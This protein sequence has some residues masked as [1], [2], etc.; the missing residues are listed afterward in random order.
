MESG[1]GLGD[2]QLARGVVGFL[3][4]EGI[5]EALDAV[6]AGIDGRERGGG[7]GGGIGLER[8]AD[9]LESVWTYSRRSSA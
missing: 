7:F 5:K 1:L 6:E 4:G 8:L 9:C 2:F 3:V